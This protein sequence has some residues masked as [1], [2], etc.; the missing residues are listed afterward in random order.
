[1]YVCMYVEIHTE[2]C[3]HVYIPHMARISNSLPHLLHIYTY[4]LPRL[5]HHSNIYIYIYT[6][7]IY[8]YFYVYIYIC[9]HS[10]TQHTHT[11]T[12]TTQTHTDAHIHTHRVRKYRYT[13]HPWRESQTL[14]RHLRQIHPP[15]RPASHDLPP[16]LH[17]LWREQSRS[18]P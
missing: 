16:N 3:I 2:P 4:S 1:M 15:D 17:F 7:T 18:L 11:H 9:M 10:Q 13:Y 12:H 14:P 6:H 5:L 8:S